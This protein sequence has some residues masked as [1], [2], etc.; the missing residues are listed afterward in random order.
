MLVHLGRRDEELRGHQCKGE[1]SQNPAAPSAC[2]H[3]RGNIEF[4]KSCEGEANAAGETEHHHAE[5]TDG[6]GKR[7]PG[8]VGHAR[9]P[10][11]CPRRCGQHLHKPTRS[12]TG[13]Q[14]RRQ[15]QHRGSDR[16]QRHNND[17]IERPSAKQRV[18][19]GFVTDTRLTAHAQPPRWSSA[20]AIAGTAFPLNY[21]MNRRRPIMP[22]HAPRTSS[23]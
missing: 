3:T 9:D 5:M 13:L 10:P 8:L 20:P 21:S 23:C 11:K 17:G 14:R 7:K 6:R 16:C 12:L 22:P 19:Y 18:Q 4:F 1:H 15:Q 2:I